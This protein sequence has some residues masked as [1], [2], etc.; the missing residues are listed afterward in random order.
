MH[1]PPTSIQSYIDTV[2]GIYIRTGESRRVGSNVGL[3]SERCQKI[4]QNQLKKVK[5]RH[6]RQRK[7]ALT[8]GLYIGQ[9][10]NK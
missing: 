3:Y 6:K 10:W 8:V 2:H 1:C 4:K 7:K 5:R 9:K